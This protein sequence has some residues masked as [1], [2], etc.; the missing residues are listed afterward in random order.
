MIKFGQVTEYN[1]KTRKA[2]ITYIRPD[3]C[4]KCGACGSL[5]QSGTIQLK[6]DCKQG[7]WVRVVLPD[8][9]FLS[10]AALAYIVPL[11]GF[12]IGL[13]G[14]YLL[15]GKSELWAL[16]GSLLG[17]LVSLVILRIVDQKISGNPSWTPCV[18][19]VYSEK[20]MMDDIGC[21]GGQ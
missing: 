15:S 17:V 10:A 19:H 14:G 3:A 21:D 7:D 1:E 13:L 2:T 4:A 18:D 20:P 8:G 5:N 11:I 9:R 16:G 12:F 6:A